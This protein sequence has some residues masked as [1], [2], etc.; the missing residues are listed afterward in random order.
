MAEIDLYREQLVKRDVFLP[1]NVDL[2]ILFAQHSTGD[3]LGNRDEFRRRLKKFDIFIPELFGFSDDDSNLYSRVSRGYTKP[4]KN[5][6]GEYPDFETRLL[7]ELYRTYVSVVF[8]DVQKNDTVVSESLTNTIDKSQFFENGFEEAIVL[9][10]A[11]YLRLA[12]SEEKRENAILRKIGPA[13]QEIIDK[14]PKLN[15]KNRIK[16]LMLIGLVHK[17]IFFKLKDVAERQRTETLQKTPVVISEVMESAEKSSKQHDHTKLA[18]HFYP[19]E[20][21]LQDWDLRE[22]L[23]KGVGVTLISILHPELLSRHNVLFNVSGLLSSEEI[24]LIYD[25]LREL[26]L[27]RISKDQAEII[28]S[29]APILGKVR[30]LINDEIQKLES[31]KN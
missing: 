20:F 16:V 30:S 23:I 13:L 25:T 27:S 31:R 17:N 4:P 10:Q 7:D 29:S 9:I 12:E 8:V 19:D 6:V 24:R 22:S 3:D 28:I 21:K 1:S 5:I 26:Y 2:T 18:L 15:N 11:G 14:N